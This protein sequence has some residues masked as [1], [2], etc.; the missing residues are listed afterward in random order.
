MMRSHNITQT[1]ALITSDPTTG[2][3]IPLLLRLLWIVSLTELNFKRDR[4]FI[5]ANAA[6]LLLLL[7]GL[8]YFLVRLPHI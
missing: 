5:Y 4:S 8:P 6:A 3:G 7:F 2:V 1:L